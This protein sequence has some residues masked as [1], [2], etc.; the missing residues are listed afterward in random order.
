M[1]DPSNASTV[2]ASQFEAVRRVAFAAVRSAAERHR[3]RLL[4]L[5]NVLDVR[6]GFKFRGGWITDEPALV[7]TVARKVPEAQL[8][9]G[10]VIPKEIDGIP[11]DVA[12]AGP[13]QLARAAQP[14]A[15]ARGAAAALPEEEPL[16]LPGSEPEEA[17]RGVARGGAHGYRNPDGLQLKPVRAAMTVTCH[18][19]PDAGWPTLQKFLQGTQHT[20]TVAMY[21]FTARH[22]FEAVK[23]AMDR[24]DGE[25]RLSLDPNAHGAR[26]KGEM[27]KPEVTD[28]LKVDLDER[29]DFTK[30]AVGVLYPNAY[31]IKV[32]VRDGKAFWLSSGNWQNSNQPPEDLAKLNPSALRKLF[33]SHNR[34]WHVVVEHPGLAKV[35]EE[36]I[37]FD[38]SEARRVQAAGR[39]PVAPEAELPDLLVPEELF[40][41]EARAAVPVRLFKPL[42]LSFTARAP[43]R[44][45]PLL[46]P[47]NYHANVK[48]L[49]ESARERLYLQNQYIKPRTDSPQEF[50]ELYEALARK[51]AEGLD[52]RIILRREGD[53]RPMLESLKTVGVR[54]DGD[55]LR[56]LAGCH[57]KGIVVDSKTVLVGSHNWSGDG[58]VFNRD[59]SL[60]LFDPKAAA[61]FEKIFLYDWENRARPSVPAERGA[62]VTP[63]PAADGARGA[64]PRGM[65]RVSW[66][67][68]FGD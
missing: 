14:R 40:E 13:L 6:P 25:L 17:E 49:I 41:E 56:L 65:R 19:S 59:A 12:P 67:E 2:P 7:V 61:Y 15:A 68:F 53:V 16:I 58:A 38:M 51:T 23:A 43:L 55:H 5:P 66:D 1:P 20:L 63:A 50:R 29:F 57:N 31:H 26:R 22:I 35:Y 33:G 28:G 37:E 39:G 3:R 64:A 34:E 24:A 10:D 45:Q 46:T 27:L 60:I 42:R 18:C 62:V 9:A 11:V 48:A 36:Y 4:R 52:V 44:V 8:G 54:T 32:A 21:D 47:D 30:A